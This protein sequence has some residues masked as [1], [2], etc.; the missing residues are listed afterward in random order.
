M[1]LKD[2]DAHLAGED[3]A[4]VRFSSGGRSTVESTSAWILRNL[5]SWATSGPVR[6]FG[7]WDQ[8]TG[9]LCGTVDANLALSGVRPGVANIS[10]AL[11]PRVRGRGY[12]SRAVKLMVEY[13]IAHTDVDTAIVQVDPENEAS[14]RVPARVGFKRVGARVTAPDECLE[15]FALR[16][17]ERV[18]SGSERVD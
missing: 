8:G 3:E 7:I 1:T 12:A 10:Y 13:L 9:S 18:P 16:L 17:R 6:A 4:M 14:L 11:H 2:V 5:E 15:T